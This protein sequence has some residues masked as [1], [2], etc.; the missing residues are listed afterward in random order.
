MGLDL[1]KKVLFEDF[2]GPLFPG[3]RLEHVL[4]SGRSGILLSGQ[5]FLII[6]IKSGWGLVFWRN[7]GGRSGGP[8]LIT[9]DFVGGTCDPAC[10]YL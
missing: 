4:L 7:P 10:L 5:P 9:V 1:S 8:R 6:L 2:P 3:E